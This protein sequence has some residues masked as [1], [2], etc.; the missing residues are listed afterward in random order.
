M[1]GPVSLPALLQ[2]ESNVDDQV[3]VHMIKMLVPLSKEFR[4]RIIQSLA[5][6]FEVTI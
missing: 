6:F 3:L 4:R 1:A 2:P 5:A